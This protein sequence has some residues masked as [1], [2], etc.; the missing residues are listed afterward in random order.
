MYVKLGN[1]QGNRRGVTRPTKNM[2]SMNNEGIYLVHIER[3]RRKN[4][5]N[6]ECSRK[7]IFP[8]SVSENMNF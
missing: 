1:N 4:K 5:K 7:T 2:M 8:K 3:I 6:E